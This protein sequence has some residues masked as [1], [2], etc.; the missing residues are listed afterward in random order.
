MALELTSSAFETTGQIPARYTCEGEDISPP[1]KW[2]FVPSDAQS[3]VLICDDPDA[4]SGTF[5]H[6]V[7]YDIPADVEELPPSVPPEPSLEWGAQQGRNDFG[8]IGYGGPCPP[9]GSTHEYYF[10]LYALN[11]ELDLPPGATREQVL[12]R[13]QDSIVEKTEITGQYNRSWPS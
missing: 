6:W 10:R 12:D 1:L 5:S 9:H 8:N 11:E 3:L 2:N 13:I 7:L 4:P